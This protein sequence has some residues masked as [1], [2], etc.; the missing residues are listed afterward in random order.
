MLKS[1]TRETAEARRRQLSYLL[2]G[3][4]VYLPGAAPSSHGEFRQDPHLLYFT[5]VDQPRCDAVLDL[6]YHKLHLF[7]PEMSRD[8]L[9]WHDREPTREEWA[10]GA[11]AESARPPEEL[12]VFLE[13]QRGRNRL[14]HS[15][16][17]HAAL[18]LEASDILTDAVI[19]LRL[20]KSSE[21]VSAIEAALD[22]TRRAHLMAM[23]V[24]HPGAYEHEVQ[25][26][27]EA[28]F[29]AA[30]VASAYAPIATCRGE[31]LH[32]VNPHRRLEAGQLFLLDA[33]AALRNSYTSDVTR[34][35]PVDGRF[36]E[37]QARIYDIVLAAQRAG[38]AAC[39]SGRLY[40]DVHEQASREIIRGLVDFGLMRGGEDELYE[41]DAHAVFFPH[42]VGHLL[43]LDVH[44]ME[45]ISEDRVGY[46]DG[47]ERR[48]EL[49][50]RRF[51]RLNREMAAGF[52]VTVEPGIYF[53]P[54]YLES[55][56]VAERFADC[57]DFEKAREML[58]F[59]GIR[60]EDDVLVTEE[61]PRV[62][63]AAIPKERAELE[64]LV[65][66]RQAWVEELRGL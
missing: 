47:Q 50:G 57:I 11:G 10:E 15:L 49:L 40:G 18:G 44:D 23:G 25:A 24:T 17:A 1:T 3:G 2:S 38:I 41:R 7:L 43:G 21:E 39:Q 27:V 28:V 59:G 22:V 5:G 42:G 58:D 8:D 37:D 52:V 20:C 45:D 26:A 48:R 9:V 36:S 30:G 29:R 61:E 46:S 16:R 19:A 66:G 32:A 4:L 63:S 56:E 54:G 65:G 33:G 53:V 62:L 51:L 12:A 13:E 34:T 14:I 6:D 60:I 31:V 64:A 35:W 55:P